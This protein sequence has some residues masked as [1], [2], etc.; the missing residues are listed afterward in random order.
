MVSTEQIEAAWKIGADVVLLIAPLFERGHTEVCLDDIIERGHDYDLEVLLEV[1]A[2]EEFEVAL[3]TKA[4]M[5]GINNR[6]LKALNVDLNTTRKILENFDRSKLGNRPIISESGIRRPED[7]RFLRKY[8][9]DAFLI[10]SSIMM[11][12]DV[13]E[14]VSSLVGACNE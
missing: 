14:F 4:D 11:A 5:I 7:V 1:H 10:G 12:D 9:V 13:T 3:S 2:I 6:D 8:G